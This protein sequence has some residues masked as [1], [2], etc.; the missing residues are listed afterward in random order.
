[1][2][3]RSEKRN[4]SQ[5]FDVIFKAYGLVDDFYAINFVGAVDEL[6]LGVTGAGQVESF[7]VAGFVGC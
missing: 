7:A 3:T 2:T 5:A 1:M 6:T 4:I